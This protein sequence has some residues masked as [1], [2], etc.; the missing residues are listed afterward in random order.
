MSVNVKQARASSGPIVTRTQTAPVREELCHAPTKLAGDDYPFLLATT[1]DDVD[2]GEG[3]TVLPS[4]AAPTG[5]E[6]SNIVQDS[7]S[8]RF[9]IRKGRLLDI[10]LGT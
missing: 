1:D 6:C 9:H 8:V 3:D 10:L 7:L 5:L 4:G 2:D